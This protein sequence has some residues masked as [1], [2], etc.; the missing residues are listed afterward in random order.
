MISNYLQERIGAGDFPSAVYLIAEKGNIVFLEAL[1]NA[2]VVPEVIP[3][4]TDTIYD[5]A[6]VTKVAV[7]ALLAAKLV[8]ACL[9]GLDARVGDLLTKTSLGPLGDVTVRQV[10]THTTGLPGWLPFYLLVAER[11][12][13]LGEIA[14]WPLEQ[15][16]KVVYGDPNFWVLTFIV[17]KLFGKPINEAAERLIFEPL[18]LK[19]TT[20]T[21]SPKLKSRVAA[22]E[23]GTRFERQLCKDLGF[24]F[25]ENRVS[26]VEGFRDEQIWGEVHDENAWFF[27]NVCGHAGLFSTAEE[28]LVIAKQF[29]AS[30]TML[31]KPETCELFTSNLTE[32]MNEDRSF[33]FELASSPNST[34]GLRMSPQ[35]FGHLGFTGTS[36]WIDPVKDRIF[37]LLTN[38]THARDLP[39]VNMN[40]IRRRFHELA[41]EALEGNR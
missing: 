41:V 1:G 10:V 31:L 18:R 6:S 33:C 27:G 36:L 39:F 2:V 25:T 22:S 15:P 3:A 34:A 8:E 28:I 17:E 9:L 40:P 29:L 11:D 23:N 38:R 35:S 24:D 14:R 12:D 37:I 20:Y 5:L 13:I 30:S 7:T 26:G 32:G 4:R 21:P 16:P 19:D